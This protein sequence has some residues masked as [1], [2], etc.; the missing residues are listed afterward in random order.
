MFGTYRLV[1]ACLV[2]LS[3]FGL[4]RAGFNP[5]QWAVLSFYVLSGFLMEHQFHRLATCRLFYLDRFLRIYPLFVIVLL[6]AALRTNSSG[7]VILVNSF[8]FPLNYS[9]FTGTPMIIGPSWSLACEAHF[10]LLVPLFARASTPWV[11]GIALSSIGLFAVSPFLPNS[12]FWAYTGLPGILFAFLSGILIRRQDPVFLRWLWVVFAGLL[13]A[14]A[15]SK[16]SHSGLPTGIHINVC[17]GYLIALPMI[18]WLAS[19]SP[20]VLWD[21]RLGLLAYPLFLAHEPV[22]RF[23]SHYFNHA[24]MFLLLL[25]AMAA[26]AVLVLLVEKPFDRIRYKIRKQLGRNA[27]S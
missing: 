9:S 18:Q 11:R 7:S 5:G 21:Q 12:T 16:F 25:A 22:G 27:V 13:A 8:L 20:K 10:Y 3:H 15:F 1:L 6:L 23:I 14:F 26:S 2:A 24:S 19:L 4:V 17:V